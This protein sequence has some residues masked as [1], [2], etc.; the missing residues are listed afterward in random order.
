[1]SKFYFRLLLAGRTENLID[2]FLFLVFPVSWIPVR[3]ASFVNATVTANKNYGVRRNQNGRIY[4]FHNWIH[5]G[6]GKIISNLVLTSCLARNLFCCFSILMKPR[7]VLYD[8]GFMPHPF[9]KTSKF[10]N[11]SDLFLKFLSTKQ[12]NATGFI[13]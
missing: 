9:P 1:M 8:V 5:S 3:V 6:M 11:E 12:V 4:F 13:N 7:K 2:I 10:V